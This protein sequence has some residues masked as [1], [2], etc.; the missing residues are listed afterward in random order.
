MRKLSWILRWAGVSVTLCT[1][2]LLLAQSRVIFKDG[3]FERVEKYEI[4]KDRVRFWSSERHEWEET[5]LSL[6]DLDATKKFNEEEAKK[7]EPLKAQSAPLAAPTDKKARLEREATEPAK[8][9]KRPV[10]ELARGITL[11]EAYGIFLVDRN[12]LVELTQAQTKKKSDRGRAVVNLVSPAPLLRQKYNIVLEGASADTVVRN[13]KPELFLHLPEERGG[14][15]SLFRMKTEKDHR[16]L[17][18][19][20]RSQITGD[21]KKSN[22]FILTPVIR[23]APNV[24]KIYPVEPLPDGQYCLVE[25]TLQK[26]NLLTTVWDFA[27]AR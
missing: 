24:F 14:N 27:I 20:S 1:L 17:Q 4:L 25:M 13:P 15:F 9:K 22:Q 5:P 19:I 26:N 10:I 18:E 6:V 11:P 16:V 21:E 2:T 7:L 23:V 12:V 3:S 8:E